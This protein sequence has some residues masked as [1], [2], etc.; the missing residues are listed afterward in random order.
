VGDFNK[1]KLAAALHNKAS[2]LEKQG[3]FEAA[4][5]LF[6]KVP[7]INKETLGEMHLTTAKSYEYI[8]QAY[9]R[10]DR[11]EEDAIKSYAKA[12]NIYNMV[13]GDDNRHTKELMKT[14]K[15]LKCE[16][17]AELLNEQGLL[18]QTQGDSKK[19][20]KLFQEALD[21]YKEKY[22]VH[23]GMAPIYESISTVKVVQG[24]LEDGI[25]ASA[26]ALKIRR[27]TDGDDHD[28]TK[29]CM[30][31]HRSLLRRLLENRG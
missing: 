4:T 27:R 1:S 26:E 8:A 11:R 15:L 18:M 6:I 9:V 2:L 30:E 31:T 5:E 23:S 29:L 14:R 12:I 20:I 3:N 7:M 10:Q 17:N 21:S 19:A 16:K 22:T 24:L 13:L 28:D 25:A